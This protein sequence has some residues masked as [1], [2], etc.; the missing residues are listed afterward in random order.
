MQTEQAIDLEYELEVQ[1]CVDDYV[2]RQSQRPTKD[3]VC[4]HC[5]TK[6]VIF[7]DDCNSCEECDFTL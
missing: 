3:Y 1:A 4:P 2:L 7:T 6:Q 5:G